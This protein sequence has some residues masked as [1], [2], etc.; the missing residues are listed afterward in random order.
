MRRKRER[1][2]SFVCSDKGLPKTVREYREKYKEISRVL[3]EHPEILNRVH[4]DLK[5]LSEGGPEGRE[6]DFTSETLL[7]ALV[8]MMAEGLSY[9]ETI[10]RIA[11]S[12]FLQDFIRTRKKAVMD[13]TFLNRAFKAIRPVTWKRV[14]CGVKCSML[15]VGARSERRPPPGA[16][17]LCCTGHE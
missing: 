17:Q 7:R 10:V 15:G 1:I 12:D 11:D 14:S 4:H 16:D 2:F 8:V 6:G 13:H 5:Q 3:D 9:R